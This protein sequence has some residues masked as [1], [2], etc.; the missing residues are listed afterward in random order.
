VALSRSV[1]LSTTRLLSFAPAKVRAHPEVVRYYERLEAE[2]PPEQRPPAAASSSQHALG[3]AAAAPAA[4][5]GSAAPLLSEDQRERMRANKAAALAKAAARKQAEAQDAARAYEAARAATAS[6]SA[7]ASGG[8]PPPPAARVLAPISHA[9]S[10]PSQPPAPVY[11][12]GP[13]RPACPYGAAC[14]RRN[15]EH[16]RDESHPPSHPL[17]AAQ[18]QGVGTAAPSTGLSQGAAGMS[19]GVKPPGNGT[20][21]G[22]RWA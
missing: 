5:G 22:V 20:A 16:F 11:S 8:A 4:G 19:V 14:Y 1:S 10:Q 6:A 7:P 9:A 3:S 2:L 13:G 15:P 12:C 21:T 17:L 18:A